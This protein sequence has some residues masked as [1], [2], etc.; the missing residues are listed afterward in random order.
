MDRSGPPT[1]PALPILPWKELSDHLERCQLALIELINTKTNG[2]VDISVEQGLARELIGFNR[3]YCQSAARLGDHGRG[4]LLDVMGDLE[5]A[6]LEISN[7]QAS[8]SSAEFAELRQRID[9]G[10]IL[11][12]VKILT[13]QVRARE[14][15]INQTAAANPS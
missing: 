12:K 6:L 2:P 1:A 5:H 3:L 15:Q 9:T 11:F 13:S 14:G 7:S 4:D 8:L 10:G